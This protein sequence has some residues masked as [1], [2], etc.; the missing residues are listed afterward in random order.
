MRVLWFTG[1]QLPALTGQGLTRAG[2]QE[3]L[4]QC[5]ETWQ[6]GIELGIL[7][8]GPAAREPLVRGN[9]VYYTVPRS[10][11]RGGLAKTW[12]AWQHTTFTPDEAERCLQVARQFKADLVHF[13]G[14]ENFFGL[15]N[16]KLETP[17]LLSIQAVING[18]YPFLFDDLGWKDIARQVASRDFI[19]GQGSIHRWFTLKKYRQV[20][21]K[22]LQGC[23]NYIG[24]T[25]WDRAM[26]AALAPQARYYH[27]DEALAEVFYGLEWKQEQT[28]AEELIYCTNSNSAFKGALTLAKAMAIL[29]QRG[30]GSIKLHMAGVEPGSEVGRP[31]TRFIREQGLEQ[32]ILLPGR[33][34]PQQI[35]TEMLKAKAFVLPSHMDNS[36]NSLCEAML[37]GM[38]CIAA[39]V[40]GVPSLVRHGV[41]GLLYHDRDPYMLADGIARLLADRGLAASLG[42]RARQTALARHD[43]QSIAERTAGIYRAV[44][45][46]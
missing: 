22:I 9:A 5:L 41:D 16:E 38:P 20:E 11:P 8:F 32:N 44:L 18:L 4:R 28:S 14:T 2:W 1:V 23:K 45:E 7:A 37:M 36:P 17:A 31:L 34:T 40:G 3:S 26:I 21:K 15:L 6:P 43:R 25:D 33:L 24:R 42:G 27:C 30:Q 13:H 29:K 19:R 39:Q 12:K 10:T 46:T 35:V